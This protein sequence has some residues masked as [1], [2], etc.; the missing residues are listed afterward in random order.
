MDDPL[1][2]FATELRRLRQEAGFSPDELARRA[3]LDPAE[4]RRLEGARRHAGVRVLTR[5]VPGST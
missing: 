1:L 5:L 4:I 3:N 2:L